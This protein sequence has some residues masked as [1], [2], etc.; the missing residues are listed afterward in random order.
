M[1]KRIA[2]V[3]LMAWV[4]FG[5]GFVLAMHVTDNPAPPAPPMSIPEGVPCPG[6]PDDDLYDLTEVYIDGSFRCDYTGE[7]Y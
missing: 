3:A 7:K 5:A 6:E 2:I 4:A 1:T